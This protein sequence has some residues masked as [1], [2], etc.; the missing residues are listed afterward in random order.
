M[1]D[2]YNIKDI[3]YESLRNRIGYVPQDVLLFSGTI[4]ENIAFGMN[5]VSMEEVVEAA[6]KSKAHDFINKLP[7]RYETMVG[8]RG[9]NLSGGQKQRIAIARAI[10]KIPIFLF[11][12]KRQVI[13]I[14]LQNR[15]FIK[16]LIGLVRISRQLS[17]P[18]D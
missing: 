15:L 8:E 3:S 18:I 10:L 13:W 6:K 7:L 12:M 1:I 2:D 9:S 11:S 4:R 16:L 17:L 14:Q 5:N